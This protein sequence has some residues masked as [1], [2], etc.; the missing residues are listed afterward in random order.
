MQPSDI[1]AAVLSRQRDARV[2]KEANGDAA[3]P[4]C[5]SSGTG[6]SVV[7]DLMQCQM[8]RFDRGLALRLESRC[9]KRS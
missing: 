9:R 8:L 6:A 2:P 4:Q 7:R 1:G 3:P 5:P